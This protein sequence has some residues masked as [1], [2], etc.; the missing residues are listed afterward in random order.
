MPGLQVFISP[1]R[2]L[3][4]YVRMS[5]SGGRKALRWPF[6][7]CAWCEDGQV[8]QSNICVS[9]RHA[10][11]VPPCVLLFIVIGLFFCRTIGLP[12]NMAAE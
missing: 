6:A 8:R 5:V 1:P 12:S 10:I 11:L 3:Q 4:S 7:V 9:H 2:K